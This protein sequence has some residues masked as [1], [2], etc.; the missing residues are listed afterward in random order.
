MMFQLYYT[1]LEKNLVEH[2]K[3]HLIALITTLILL[4]VVAT[5]ISTAAAST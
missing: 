1:A 5:A 2:E 4:E 3:S